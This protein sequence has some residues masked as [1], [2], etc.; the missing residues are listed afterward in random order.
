MRHLLKLK[1]TIYALLG[2]TVH[3]A[4]ADSSH[5]VCVITKKQHYRADD[6]TLI[7]GPN[8]TLPG[9]LG[10]QFTVNRITGE[11]AGFNSHLGTFSKP[12]FMQT[13]S[14]DKIFFVYYAEAI[15]GIVPV[16]NVN[17][18]PNVSATKKP[19]TVLLGRLVF[20]GECE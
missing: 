12:V 15:D 17:I 14:R 20:E 6:P 3:A 19:L 16:L 11:I 9:R 8:D 4:S 5:F 18:F 1:L 10:T 2:L 13:A 7:D